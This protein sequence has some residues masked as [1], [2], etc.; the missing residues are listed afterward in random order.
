MREHDRANVPVLKM[1]VPRQE[2]AGVLN[3]CNVFFANG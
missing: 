1:T 2:N 3:V